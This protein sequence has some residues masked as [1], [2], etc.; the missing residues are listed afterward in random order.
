LFYAAWRMRALRRA[1]GTVS[2]PPVHAS[3]DWVQTIMRTDPAVEYLHRGF[4]RILVLREVRA[5]AH[6]DVG[7]A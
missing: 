5:L 1:S 4:P 6:S 2:R 3:Q 7:L